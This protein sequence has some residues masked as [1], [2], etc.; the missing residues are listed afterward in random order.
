ML[1]GL[2][3]QG[4]MISSTRAW[5]ALAVTTNRHMPADLLLVQSVL[6]GSFGGQTRPTEPAWADA[7]A[8]VGSDD[9]MMEC[10]Q[11]DALWRDA[12]CAWK[13]LFV[14]QSTPQRVYALST[15]DLALLREEPAWLTFAVSARETW[16]RDHGVDDDS[17]ELLARLTVAAA[18][19]QQF[20]FGDSRW[21]VEFDGSP[22]MGAFRGVPT[23]QYADGLFL[24]TLECFHPGLRT[25]RWCRDVGSNL[26]RFVA[27]FERGTVDYREALALVDLTFFHKYVY[28]A[29]ILTSRGITP[30][31]FR[32]LLAKERQL[33]TDDG[34]LHR[35]RHFVASPEIEWRHLPR[36]VAVDANVI[37]VDIGLRDLIELMLNAPTTENS[38]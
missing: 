23:R 15:V 26:V 30:A 10:G 27:A 2:P 29:P 28:S 19:F 6:T 32:A 7:I 9:K 20:T 14:L 4:R 12:D 3:F 37:L 34:L 21:R 35:V 11:W 5:N 24:E 1:T 16:R 13:R 38:L 17:H 33:T 31:D 8:I 36:F 25:K 18:S 22:L